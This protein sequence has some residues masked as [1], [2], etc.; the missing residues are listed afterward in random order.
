[1]I[2]IFWKK[3]CD[4]KGVT[5]LFEHKECKEQITELER[6]IANAE[7]CVI[8]LKNSQQQ[9]ANSLGSRS[10]VCLRTKSNIEEHQASITQYEKE[11]QT[12]VDKVNN[13]K[14]D[15]GE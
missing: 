6:K 3:V 5:P 1:V 14:I 2:N 15:F 8:E 11:K 4:N 12:L 10:F 7:E 9:A 13:M